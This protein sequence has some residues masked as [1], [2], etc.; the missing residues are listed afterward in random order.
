MLQTVKNGVPLHLRTIE[1][2]VAPSDVASSEVTWVFPHLWCL[3]WILLQYSGHEVANCN[4]SF[5]AGAT[6]L[7]SLIYCARFFTV[8]ECTC[9]LHR[10]AL[11]KIHIIMKYFCSVPEMLAWISRNLHFSSYDI[12]RPTSLRVIR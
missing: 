7:F 3:H 2:D 9:A 5:V 4:S 1:G 12:I 10:N 8:L 6:W 11:D